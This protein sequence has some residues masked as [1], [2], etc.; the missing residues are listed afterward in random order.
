MT[1]DS[2]VEISTIMQLVVRMCLTQVLPSTGT[3]PNADVGSGT[4]MRQRKTIR[5]RGRPME[6]VRFRA[7]TN[8]F[9]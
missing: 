9:N 4:R 2:E 8:T 1:F 7:V 5:F 3:S 6:A